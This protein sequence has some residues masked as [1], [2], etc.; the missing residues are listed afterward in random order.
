MSGAFE[1]T[2]AVT[3]PF[4]VTEYQQEGICVDKFTCF[5]EIMHC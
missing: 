5:I 1:R 3:E 4:K 2:R